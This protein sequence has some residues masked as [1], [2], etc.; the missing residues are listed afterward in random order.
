MGADAPKGAGSKRKRRYAARW[1]S[2][3]T[4]DIL[5]LTAGQIVDITSSCVGSPLNTSGV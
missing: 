5:T 2:K 1:V 3:D 4:T